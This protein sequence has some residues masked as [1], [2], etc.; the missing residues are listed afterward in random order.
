LIVYIFSDDISQFYIITRDL[1]LVE[2]LASL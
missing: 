1:Q 2:L